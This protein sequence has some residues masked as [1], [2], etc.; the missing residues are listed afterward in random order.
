MQKLNK[1]SRWISNAANGINYLSCAAI[2]LMM[3]LTCSDVVLRLLRR[4]IPGTYELVGYLGAMV[5]AFSLAYTSVEKGHI[6]VELLTGRLPR[7]ARSLIEGLGS[8]AGAVFFA[9]ASWQC[10]VYGND[11]KAGGEVS[12]T[13]EMPIYPFAYAIFLG[14]TALTVVLLFEAVRDFRRLLQQ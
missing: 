12:L 13:L 1:L 3:L 11:L 4:P 5:V 10:A 7:R 2:I 9:L 8:L 6:W 14:C